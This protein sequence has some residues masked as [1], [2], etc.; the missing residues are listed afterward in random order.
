M[1]ICESKLKMLSFKKL[2]EKAPPMLSQINIAVFLKKMSFCRGTLN[3]FDT[4]QNDILQ[5]DTFQKSTLADD[6]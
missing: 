5:N 2:C 3:H 6:T 4:N 1:V